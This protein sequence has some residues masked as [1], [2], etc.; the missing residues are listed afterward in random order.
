MVALR[1]AGLG[2]AEIADRYQLHPWSV[3]RI[4]IEAGEWIPPVFD[5]VCQRR[6]CGRP[7]RAKV[8]AKYCR[9][10]C[11]SV[12]SHR[13]N[14]GGVSSHAVLHALERAERRRL[15]YQLTGQW[16][17]EQSGGAA[18]QVRREG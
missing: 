13:R 7:F 2:Y 10:T 5:H 16:L 8:G 18:R 14:R 15:H 1:Q 6:D 3:S 4:I 11:A 17:T 9:P 12:E